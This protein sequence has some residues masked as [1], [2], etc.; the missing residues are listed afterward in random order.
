MRERLTIVSTPP[1]LVYPNWD[2]VTDSS[3]P[4]LSYCDV[5]VNGIGTTLEEEHDDHPVCT[6]VIITRAIIESECHWTPLDLE[7]GSIVWSSKRLRG[8]ATICGVLLSA[9]LSI[10]GR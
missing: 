8:F 2:A 3:R 5:S 7:A 6:I 9:C 1:T 4:L 10:T